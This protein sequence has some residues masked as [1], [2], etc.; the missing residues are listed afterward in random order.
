MDHG[1]YLNFQSVP[2]PTQPD[3]FSLHSQSSV[4]SFPG[5]LMYT[6]MLLPDFFNPVN[7]HNEVIIITPILPVTSLINGGPFL[8]DSN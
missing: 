7:K 5:S 4:K 6:N 3:D 8:S 2:N 1:L